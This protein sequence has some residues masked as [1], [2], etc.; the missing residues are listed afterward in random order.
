MQTAREMRTRIIDKALNDSDYRAKLLDDP[1]TA[2][3]EELGV[4]IPG[5][6]SIQVHEEDATCAHLVL[7]PDSRLSGRDLKPV[8]AGAYG[9]GSSLPAEP[10]DH[11]G[12]LDW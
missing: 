9:W 4:T 8:S 12:G 1:R 7:P 11:G 3:R 5:S 6:L 10:V 2:I